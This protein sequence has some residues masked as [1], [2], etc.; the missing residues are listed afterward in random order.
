MAPNDWAK[1][2]NQLRCILDLLL[3][4]IAT[5]LETMKMANGLPK[6]EF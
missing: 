1:E 3:S 6:L 4:A 5:G 2:H